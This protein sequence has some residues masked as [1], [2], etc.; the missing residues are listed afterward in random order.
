MAEKRYAGQVDQRDHGLA[1]DIYTRGNTTGYVQ[2]GLKEQESY[3][4]NDLSNDLSSLFNSFVDAPIR[5]AKGT[6]IHR[7]GTSFF[8][9]DYVR[10]AAD[11]ADYRTK[12]L[13]AAGEDYNTWVSRV[14]REFPGFR[15]HLEE[16][17]KTGDPT[18]NRLMNNQFVH[19]TAQKGGV[20]QQT[21]AEMAEAEKTKKIETD[22]Q[23]T[24]DKIREF[25]ETL[26][27]PLTL[28]D[29][30]VQNIMQMTSYATQNEARR[31]G[32]EGPL[33]LANTQQ[34]MA[35]GLSMMNKDRNAQYMGALGF[36]NDAEAG[37]LGEHLARSQQTKID[38]Q[39][40]WEKEAAARMRENEAASAP[41]RTA[42]GVMGGLGTAAASIF[43]GGLAGLGI[44]AAG[45]IGTSL[46]SN[47]LNSAPSANPNWGRGRGLGSS[48]NKYGGI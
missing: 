44:G 17:A 22:R 33:S 24:I 9:F 11:D 13:P 23:S 37:Q 32:V 4:A 30:E 35:G 42:L 20:S 41:G 43:T 48:G 8:G 3:R 7:S 38:R 46:A 27:K 16:K 12:F 39:A 5:Q 10:H 1:G 15:S 34:A 36:Q 47:A 31:R 21:A 40:Q 28:E 45:A 25:A 18:I 2:P 6:P 29:P 14:D 19:I 26:K